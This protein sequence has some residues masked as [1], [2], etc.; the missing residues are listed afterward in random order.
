[1]VYAVTSASIYRTSSEMVE[2]LKRQSPSHGHISD[3]NSESLFYHLSADCL[4]RDCPW[5]SLSALDPSSNVVVAPAA[6]T[7]TLIADLILV[8]KV[9]S[10]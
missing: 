9:F 8:I 5:R 7:H 2:H 4:G 10:G 6:M 3:H 1:M